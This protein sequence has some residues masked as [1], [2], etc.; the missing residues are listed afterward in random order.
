MTLWRLCQ[1]WKL[2]KFL[3]CHALLV[4]VV[5]VK[6]RTKKYQLLSAQRTQNCTETNPMVVQYLVRWIHKRGRFV[7]ANIILQ[8]I[9]ESLDLKSEMKGNLETFS[10]MNSFQEIWPCLLCYWDCMMSF[11]LFWFFAEKEGATCL[12]G[13]QTN[14]WKMQYFPNLN[15][16]T[17][18]N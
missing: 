1:D 18:V 4:V 15:T 9:L 16:L 11:D 17:I 13:D 6:Q 2:P 12:R 3:N 10:K 7:T 14:Q 8:I 5:V